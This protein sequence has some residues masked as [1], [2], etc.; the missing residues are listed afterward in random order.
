MSLPSFLYSQLF[1]GLPV[2]CHDFTGQAIVI[3]GGNTGL[4]LEAARHMLKLNA[5]HILLGVRNL[6][7]G[8][9]AREELQQSTGKGDR[10]TIVQ[11][12]M[13]RYESVQSF[14]TSVAKLP[15]VDAVILNA[16]KIAQ[17]FYIAEED[18]STITVNVVSTMLLA[19][20]VLPKL[21]ASA[22]SGRPSPRLVI[23]ASDRHVMT[24]LPEW[25]TPNTFETLRRN[26]NSGADDRYYA[27]KLLSV[28][29]MRQLASLTASSDPK[30][31]INGLTPGYCST[32]LVNEVGGRWGWE[33]WAMKLALARTPEQ[34]SRTLVHAAT[35]GWEGHGKYLNDCKIDDGALSAFVRSEEGNQAQLKV[36]TEL[37]EKLE[38]I[39]PGVSAAID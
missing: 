5:A 20:L 28:L 39:S 6:S 13:E 25:K 11:V 8:Q 16:G 1:V 10:I 7:K 32:G 18:E 26:T 3:T 30:V 22:E 2:P 4:G 36:W 24:N 27:S 33:L 17:D 31:V 35:L 19:L 21:R 15:R 38:R 23:V 34:G 37:V 29:C 14:A 12:D 9:A